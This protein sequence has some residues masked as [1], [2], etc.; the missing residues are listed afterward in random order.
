MEKVKN[1]IVAFYPDNTITL[2]KF[3]QNYLVEKISISPNNINLLITNV[4]VTEKYYL[5]NLKKLSLLV[6]VEKITTEIVSKLINLSENHSISELIDN[7]SKIQKKL[8]TF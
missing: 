3:A 6:K 8:L 2:L 1:I 4:T 7:C 5:T